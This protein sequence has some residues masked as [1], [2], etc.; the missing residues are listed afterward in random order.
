MSMDAWL[1][2]QVLKNGSDQKKAGHIASLKR[3]IAVLKKLKGSLNII[4]LEVRL[5]QLGYHHHNCICQ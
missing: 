1:C 5:A 4:D 3:E 2:K